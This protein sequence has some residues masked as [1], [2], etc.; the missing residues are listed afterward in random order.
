MATPGATTVVLSGEPKPQ[1]IPVRGPPPHCRRKMRRACCCLTFLLMLNLFLTL[2]ISHSICEIMSVFWANDMVLLPGG[3]QTFCNDFCVDLCVGGD[4]ECAIESCLE[5]CGQHFDREDAAGFIAD[6]MYPA[7]DEG[8]YYGGDEGIEIDVV[9]YDYERPLYGD[10]GESDRPEGLT[11][12]PGVLEKADSPLIRMWKAVSW[13]GSASEGG[14]PDPLN[15][16]Q[17]VNI[18]E[19]RVTFLKGTSF[20]S[21]DL[22]E[23]LSEGQL[24]TSDG[25][26]ITMVFS[27][28][29]RSLT[30]TF[31]YSEPA[32]IV[33]EEY[34]WAD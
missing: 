8:Y 5:R 30:I 13:T 10:E 22:V 26:L 32:A 27:E 4:F 14:D 17:I 18:S 6:E 2:H 25:E 11:A 29:D 23:S 31:G 33:Y 12:A 28:E 15:D 34:E 20:D 9:Y 21:W 24:I 1:S 19:D 16:E 3:Q 7:I